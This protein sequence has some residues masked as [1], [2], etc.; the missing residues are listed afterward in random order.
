MIRRFCMIMKFF[1]KA[2]DI[3][4]ATPDA[5]SGTTCSQAASG[6]NLWNRDERGGNLSTISA[7]YAVSYA[8]LGACALCRWSV[9]PDICSI[10][11]LMNQKA[12]VLKAEHWLSDLKE[13]F[14]SYSLYGK[15]GR[16]CQLSDHE[17][18][19][20]DATDVRSFNVW[21][22]FFFRGS[23]SFRSGARMI[24]KLFSASPN[25]SVPE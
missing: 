20:V 19:K 10:P 13:T 7:R 6:R 5:Q 25:V 21:S 8:T 1:A 9:S 17:S 14:R 12:S 3:M 4:K 2:D 22:W 16:S 24:T 15:S 11:I 18:I 23:L